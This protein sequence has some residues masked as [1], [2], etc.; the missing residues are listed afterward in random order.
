MIVSYNKLYDR[1]EKANAS[2]EN[3]YNETFH[4]FLGMLL[5]NECHKLPDR[6]IYWETSSMSASMPSLKVFFEISIFVA[7]NN[8]ANK[9]NSRSFV[10]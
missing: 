3:F 9:K 6:K 8:L 10:S 7:T 5:L 1:K 2:L 4:L